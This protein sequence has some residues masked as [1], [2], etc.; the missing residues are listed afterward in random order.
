VQTHD[1]QPVE[2]QMAGAGFF[3]A[4]HIRA[5]GDSFVKKRF[6]LFLA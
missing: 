3:N 4:A 1:G 5:A 6:Q 2:A